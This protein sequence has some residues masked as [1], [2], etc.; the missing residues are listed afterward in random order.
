MRSDYTIYPE[1]LEKLRKSGIEAKVQKIKNSEDGLAYQGGV[2]SQ[3]EIKNIFKDLNERGYYK[4]IPG[5]FKK[6]YQQVINGL[7]KEPRNFNWAI[8]TPSKK[9]VEPCELDDILLFLGDY[10]S[11][12]LGQV[13]MWDYK[14]FGFS[15]PTEFIG[16]VSAYII[17]QSNDFHSHEGYKWT[18]KRKDGSEIVSEI[19]GDTNA[20]LRIFQTDIASYPTTDPFGNPTLFR[21]Q[22]DCDRHFVSPYHSTESNLFVAVMKYIEQRQIPVPF[23]EGK[24]KGLVDWANSLSEGP[25]TCAEHFGG[26]DHE[27]MLFFSVYD[28]PIPVLDEN[29][30]TSSHSQY[31]LICQSEGWYEAYISHKGNFVLSYVEKE[32]K[33]SPTRRINAE[34]LPEDA[35]HLLKG[36]IYQ[37]VSHQGRT[38]VG[39]LLS[40]FAY[41]FSPEFEKDRQRLRNI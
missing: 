1:G 19:T 33:D 4:H 37:S 17:G 30:Q 21:P 39:Q 15:N 3:W 27:P 20:D 34:F 25:I 36:L 22:L 32:G 9:I 38:S 11:W 31:G 29:N 2:V 10:P 41:R 12:I 40:L 14:R 35:E 18:T 26:F 13:Q 16:L 7:F 23:W 28:L 24:A 8:Q 6:H 5:D